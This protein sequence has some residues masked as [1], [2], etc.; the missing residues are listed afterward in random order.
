[1]KKNKIKDGDLVERIDCPNGTEA[2]IGDIGFVIEFNSNSNR[3]S[4]IFCN[5]KIQ[6]WF[7]AYFKKIEDE[8]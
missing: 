5:G 8:I 6:N 4:T 7:K 2:K 1:M 3:F